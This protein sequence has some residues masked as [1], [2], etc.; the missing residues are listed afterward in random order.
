MSPIFDF[1]AAYSATDIRIRRKDGSVETLRRPEKSDS[2]DSN[3]FKTNDTIH[4]V[5]SDCKNVLWLIAECSIFKKVLSS[6]HN[7]V[8]VTFELCKIVGAPNSP[9]VLPPI[10][11][12][13]SC[14]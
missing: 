2:V 1:M 9:Y 6:S 11:S 13:P 14:S 3:H 7:F 12:F 8:T 4:N 10:T 5:S